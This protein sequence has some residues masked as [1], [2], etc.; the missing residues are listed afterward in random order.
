MRQAAC[1]TARDGGRVDGARNG[2]G[3]RRACACSPARKK[4]VGAHETD[5]VA[6]AALD[7]T[8]GAGE[9]GLADADGPEHDDVPVSFEEA[10]AHELGEQALVEG[11]LR[12]LVPSLECHVGVESSLGGPIVS[13][14]AVAARDP[15][16]DDEEQ[17]VLE[18]HVLFLGEDR[19]KRPSDAPNA[20]ASHGSICCARGSRRRNPAERQLMTH[21]SNA[22]FGAASQPRVHVFRLNVT[23]PKTSGCGCTLIGTRALLMTALRV[24]QWNRISCFTRCA[25]R[26]RSTGAGLRKVSLESSCRSRD[27]RVSIVGRS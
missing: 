6:V 15:V 22:R 20:H 9:E 2:G 21:H 1:S 18:S 26:A 24:S 8:E 12:G 25:G 23:M 10:Q 4:L 5:A 13:G 17:E 19:V 16:G 14:G 7:V 11:D 27:V 3:R